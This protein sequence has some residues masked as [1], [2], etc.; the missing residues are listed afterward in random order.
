MK[1]YLILLVAVA[2]CLGGCKKEQ[3]DL[4]GSETVPEGVDWQL[5]EQYVPATLQLGEEAVDVLIAMDPIHLSIYYDRQEQELMDA[6]TIYVPLSDVD[7]SRE[8]LRILDKNQDGYDD[9]C[10]PD[11]LDNGDRTLNWWVWDPAEMSYYYAPDFEQYQEDISADISWQA[12]KSF[13]RASMDTPKGPQDLLI[14][15]EEPD[16]LV[17]LDTR[18]EQLW[19]SA[20][21]PEPLSAEAKVHLQLYTYWE[22]VD[23]NG[24]GWGDLQMPCRWEE[25]ADG[26]VFQY[27]WCFLWDHENKTYVYDP[28]RS[29]N[30]VM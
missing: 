27:D 17:Y 1:R 3:S 15:V 28:Q 18:E 16:I 5:W 22:C 21:M 7:Y 12:E 20:Q 30:P 19:G 2:L 4:P 24:D 23:L 6:V 14:L 13:I 25:G 29:A 26:S 10:V 9:I 11:M 8:R